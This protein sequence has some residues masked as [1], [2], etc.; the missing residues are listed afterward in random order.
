MSYSAK[1]IHPDKEKNEDI[2]SNLPASTGERHNHKMRHGPFDFR[3][4]AC[5]I[6]SVILLFWT[7]VQ[8]DALTYISM[9]IC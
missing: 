4:P 1:P 6:L 7:L 5:F 9:S 3:Q 2:Y 8:I